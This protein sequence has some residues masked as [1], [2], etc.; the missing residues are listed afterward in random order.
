MRTNSLIL[1]S[2]MAKREAK[3]RTEK[4]Q[5]VHSTPARTKP[6]PAKAIT[7]KTVTTPANDASDDVA[8]LF[9]TTGTLSWVAAVFFCLSLVCPYFLAGFGLVALVAACQRKYAKRGE[10]KK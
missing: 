6:T 2:A 9:S 10:K 8:G 7:A 1:P 5:S 4:V 3:A